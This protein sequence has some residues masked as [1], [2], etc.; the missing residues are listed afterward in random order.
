MVSFSQGETIVLKNKRYI[1]EYSKEW[2]HPHMSYWYITSE[3]TECDERIPRSKKFYTDK[4]I[5]LNP[6]FMYKGSGYDRGHVMPAGD[7]A[8]LSR[9]EMKDSFLYS[10]ISPQTPRL[11]RGNWRKLEEYTRDMVSEG[12]TVFIVVEHVGSAGRIT[13]NDKHINIPDSLY[14]TLIMKSQIDSSYYIMKYGFK[15]SDVQNE[16]FLDNII[17]FKPITPEEFN[18]M[19]RHKEDLI[20]I[21]E[22]D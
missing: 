6:R 17:S 8:C 18:R 16:V 5:D 22:E 9:Q 1:T 4:R 13:Y 3:N 20:K 21:K 11:N 2:N 7:N 12:D 10:N 15:N 19:F 14:K